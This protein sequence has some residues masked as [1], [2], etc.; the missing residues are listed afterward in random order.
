V[1]KVKFSP[2]NATLYHILHRIFAFFVQLFKEINIFLNFHENFMKIFLEKCENDF[3]KTENFCCKPRYYM[4]HFSFSRLCLLV[5][6]Q[7]TRTRDNTI[8]VNSAT[9]YWK[10]SGIYL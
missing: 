5:V 1:V 2:K 9:S 8:C 3:H 10:L 6:S 4:F 7:R